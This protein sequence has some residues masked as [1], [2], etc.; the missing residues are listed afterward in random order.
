MMESIPLE[1]RLNFLL[2]NRPNYE[3]NQENG[4][5]FYRVKNWSG[6]QPEHGSEVFIRK[7]PRNCYEDEI[8]PLFEQLGTVYTLRLMMD[9]SGTNRGYAFLTY[10]CVEEAERAIIILDNHQI[11]I[12]HPIEVLR[13]FDNCRLFIGN[14]PKSKNKQ[15]ILNEVKRGTENVK[16]VTVY[17]DMNTKRNKGFAFVEY[18]S[19][20]DAV[21][22]RK[23]LVNEYPLWNLRTPIRVDWAKPKRKKV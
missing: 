21:M 10:S 5:R 8:I 16:D 1:Y 9:F 14:I 7:L 19:H 18:N 17:F 23:I 4:Q 13:S 11:R 2:S 12:G 15:E 3:I 22:A 20:K 6:K